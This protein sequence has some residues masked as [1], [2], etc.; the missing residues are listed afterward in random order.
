MLPLRR[1]RELSIPPARRGLLLYSRKTSRRGDDARR[2]RGVGAGP[3]VSRPSPP[4]KEKLGTNDS[5]RIK[6]VARYLNGNTAYVS[7]GDEV[8]M[9][10]MYALTG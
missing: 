8:I 1:G 6:E 3:V 9:A 5:A 4:W 2:E 7:V 10:A